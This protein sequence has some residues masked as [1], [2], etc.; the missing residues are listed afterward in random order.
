MV[1]TTIACSTPKKLAI[2]GTAING[3]PNPMAPFKYAPK[4]IA[5]R[6]MVNESRFNDSKSSLRKTFPYKRL[7]FIRATMKQLA[8]YCTAEV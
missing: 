5:T 8:L 7:F 2:V 6:T 1:S 4:A 3:R